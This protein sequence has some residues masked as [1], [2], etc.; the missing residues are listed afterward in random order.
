M[1][2]IYDKIKIKA[3]ALRLWRRYD[4]MT[5]VN[6]KNHCLFKMR[7]AIRIKGAR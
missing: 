3:C 6:K 2:K 7:T 5:T 1:K 4:I